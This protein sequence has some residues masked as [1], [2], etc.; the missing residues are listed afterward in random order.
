VPLRAVV[1]DLFDTLVD[2]HMDRLPEVVFDGRRLRST[3]GLLYEALRV[4]AEV[5]FETFVRTLA[6][7]DKELGEKMHVARIEVPTR[8]RFARLVERL[9]VDAPGLADELTE[10]HMGALFERVDPI[11]GHAELLAALHRDHRLAIC[12]NFTHAP[13][14]HRVIAAAGLAPHLDAVVISEEVGVRKPRRE[15]FE[16]TLARLGVAPAEALHV[17]DNLEAD[18]SGAAALGM[19]T[20]WVTRRV[21]D[22]HRALG[23]HRGPLPVLRLRELAELPARLAELRV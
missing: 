11:P 6:A 17:G 1:F 14:A 16:A 2:V 8:E 19:P 9:G 12:S 20:A 4:R 10:V 13:M 5:E 3:Y 18:V 23:S 7:L 21:R 22:P 15:I